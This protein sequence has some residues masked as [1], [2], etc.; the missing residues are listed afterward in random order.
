MSSLS[1]FLDFGIGN[2]IFVGEYKNIITIMNPHQSN[3]ISTIWI[4]DHLLEPDLFALVV[5]A[6]HQDFPEVVA[7]SKNQDELIRQAALYDFPIYCSCAIYNYDREKLWDANL[8][9]TL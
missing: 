8:P 4:N 3:S 9:S 6:S 1:N 5:N 7:T 2:A